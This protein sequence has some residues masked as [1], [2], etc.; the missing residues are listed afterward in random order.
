MPKTRQ[1]S[2]V[3]EAAG[4]KWKEGN[5]EYVCQHV[6]SNVSLNVWMLFLFT[7]TT[8]EFTVCIIISKANLTGLN[9]HPALLSLLM[10]LWLPALCQKLNIFKVLFI[11]SFLKTSK[12]EFLAISTFSLQLPSL[13][14]ILKLD[15]P[16][17]FIFMC[18]IITWNI[19]GQIPKAKSLT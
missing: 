19:N 8:G 10:L 14:L 1:T 15:I 13:T 7:D 16:F 4:T 3:F 6:I 17:R 18:K 9:I 11:A 2:P 5:N 12:D